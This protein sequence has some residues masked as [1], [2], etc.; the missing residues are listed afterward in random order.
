MGKHIDLQHS[1][2]NSWGVWA[3]SKSM[4]RTE[5]DQCEIWM[6]GTLRITAA[7]YSKLLLTT[8]ITHENF[9]SSVSW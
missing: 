9:W 1:T 2:T 4:S 6:Q 8:N 7:C 5:L 3:K